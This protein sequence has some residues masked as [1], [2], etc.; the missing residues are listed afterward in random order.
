MH[1]SGEA[2]V[3]ADGR[4]HY[5]VADSGIRHSTPPEIVGVLLVVEGARK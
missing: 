3:L 5:K 4:V 1:L 2:R